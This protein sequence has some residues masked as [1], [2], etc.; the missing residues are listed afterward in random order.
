MMR[1]AAISVAGLACIGCGGDDTPPSNDRCAADNVDYYLVPGC[2]EGLRLAVRYSHEILRQDTEWAEYYRI[3]SALYA[4]A[5]ITGLAAPSAVGVSREL[6]L[7]SNFGPLVSAW[8]EERL[9][10][11]DPL[12]DDIFGETAESVE[13]HGEVQTG[14]TTFIHA[15]VVHFPR[16]ASGEEINRRLSAIPETPQLE[17]DRPLNDTIVSW[18]GDVAQLAL[19]GGW[20]DCFSGCGF[21]HYWSATVGP[22]NSVQVWDLGGD[23]L[24]PEGEPIPP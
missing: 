6:F 12:V 16:E 23:P 22:D 8:S 3:M 21:Y 2:I 15:F 14:E 13:Y 24:P 19:I 9:V 17:L 5:P 20:L 18:D 1:A 11:G 10:T 4:A 7:R